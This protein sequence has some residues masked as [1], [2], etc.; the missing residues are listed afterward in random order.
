MSVPER[1]PSW[2]RFAKPQGL[3]CGLRVGHRPGRLTSSS[4]HTPK[5]PNRTAPTGI[6][7]TAH[8]II[9]TPT[10][11]P[12]RR[13]TSSRERVAAWRPQSRNPPT[14]PRQA[15]RRPPST[16]PTSGRH[17]LR[18]M[19]IGRIGVL[20]SYGTPK[21]WRRRLGRPPSSGNLAGNPKRPATTRIVANTDTL[22]RKYAGGSPQ[23]PQR[24]GGSRA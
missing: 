2:L 13:W 7:R 5:P 17:V 21:T 24:G 9:A 8:W 18:M 20:S 3:V 4:R 15:P 1:E 11:S 22:N 14:H 12:Y 10:I 6:P 19:V 16:P 23:R